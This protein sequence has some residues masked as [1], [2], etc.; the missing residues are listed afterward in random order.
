MKPSRL[1]ICLWLLGLVIAYIAGTL[2]HQ[3][4]H[5]NDSISEKAPS[6]LRPLKLDSDPA[7]KLSEVSQFLEGALAMQSN[8]QFRG[9]FEA[10]IPSLSE[11]STHDALFILANVW[12]A[13]DP[14]A[15][16]EWLAKLEFKD[17][18][19]PFLFSAFSQ[20]A[21]LDPEA[22]QAWLNGKLQSEG[23]TKDYMLASLIRGLAISDPDKALQ[24][25]LQ[26][27]S[28]PERTGSLDF[29]INSWKSF[30]LK[31]AFSQVAS[32]PDSTGIF[33]EHAIQKLCSSLSK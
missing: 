6:S 21:R 14:V 7:A 13:K 25:L 18:R 33:K 5:L 32:I 19:N 23:A 22:A 31:Y 1:I 27:P 24:I 11:P 12:A 28:S 30:S 3:S 20:W 26:A 2:R 10:L 8:E 9:S 16:T 29:L 17:P 4:T 15:A